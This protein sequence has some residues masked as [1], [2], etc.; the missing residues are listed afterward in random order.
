VLEAILTFARQPGFEIQG[1]QA[2]PLAGPKG[3]REFLV[4]LLYDQ[5]E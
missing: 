3:N 4:N 2:S 5:H 1:V